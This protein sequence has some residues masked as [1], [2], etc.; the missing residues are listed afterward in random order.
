MKEII[1]ISK[2]ELS[3][4]IEDTLKQHLKPLIK[5]LNKKNDSPEWL[6]VRQK[7]SIENISVSMVYKLIAQGKYETRKVGRKTQVKA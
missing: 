7:A 6:T 1:V 3:G 5:E 2:N 4:L